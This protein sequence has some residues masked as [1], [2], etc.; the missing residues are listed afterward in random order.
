MSFAALLLGAIWFVSQP[1][2][3]AIEHVCCRHRIWPERPDPKPS[4]DAVMSHA[5]LEQKV[6]QY[7]RNSQTLNDCQRPITADQLQTEMDRMAEHTKQPRVFRELFAALGN[8]LFAIDGC[9]A[10]QQRL[11]G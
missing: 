10:Y 9:S 1:C 5:Q 7:L 8:D 3:A 2:A 6:T 11:F 4:L